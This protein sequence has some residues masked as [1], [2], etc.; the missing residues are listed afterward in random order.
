VLPHHVVLDGR[1]AG[2][3]QRTT[4]R[5]SVMMQLQLHAKPTRG[6]AAALRAEARRYAEFLGADLT[7]L[8]IQEC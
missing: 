3:W 1:D 7:T 6:H 2:H 4:A 5:G 8:D